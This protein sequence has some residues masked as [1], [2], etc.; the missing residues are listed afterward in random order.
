MI[1]AE[2]SPAIVPSNVP[3]LILAIVTIDSS[4]DAAVV[5]VTTVA[6]S[7]ASAGSVV[8]VNVLV[9]PTLPVQVFW[10]GTIPVAGV[11]LLG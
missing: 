2:P 8:I 11:T 7:V 3:S 4:L 5:A 9:S 10:L 6:E 1:V